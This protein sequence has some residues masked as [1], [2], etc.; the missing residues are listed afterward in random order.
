MSKQIQMCY[1][2]FGEEVPYDEL[3]KASGQLGSKEE[4]LISRLSDIRCNIYNHIFIKEE[5]NGKE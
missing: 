3:L 5:N 2:I 1:N 4:Q